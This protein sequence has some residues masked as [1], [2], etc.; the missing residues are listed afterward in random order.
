MIPIYET[1]YS[2]QGE[3]IH[4]GRSAFFIRT[5]GC[6]VHCTWCDSAGTWHPDYIPEKIQKKSAEELVATAKQTNCDFVVVTGGEPAIHDLS[7]LTSLLKEQSIPC[8]IETSGGFELKGDFQ[9]V[10]LSPKRE[11]LP[12]DETLKSAN[13]I[14]VIVDGEGAIDEWHAYLN[15]HQVQIPIWLNIEWSQ[16]DNKKLKEQITNFIKSEGTPYR[17]GYQFHKLFKADEMDS[18]SMNPVPLGGDLNLGY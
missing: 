2:W 10:T 3:G 7:P 17:V 18:N 5:F 8:H 14:K 13:E 6:P 16:R 1:F 9:W 12:L 15:A 4:F 11:K